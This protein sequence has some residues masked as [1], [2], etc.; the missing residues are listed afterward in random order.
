M[1]SVVTVLPG[2]SLPTTDG[3]FSLDALLEAVCSAGIDKTGCAG[4]RFELVFEATGADPAIDPSAA[5]GV[6]AVA[7][8]AGEGNFG[9]TAVF[10][11]WAEIAAPGADGA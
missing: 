4:L 5:T 10:A 9:S 11:G 3:L 1:V 7:G 6:V 2:D 8:A